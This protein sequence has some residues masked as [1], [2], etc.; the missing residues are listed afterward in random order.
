MTYLEQLALI[1][2]IPLKEGDRKVISCPICYGQKKLSI[3]KID[4]VIR[5]NCY[6]ASCEGKGI[7]AGKRSLAAAKVYMKSDAQVKI[8]FRRPPPSITTA[9]ENHPPALDYLE[10][11]N[12]LT[13]YERGLI[14]V[15]YAPAESR[16]LFYSPNGAV[17]RSLGRGPKWMTY[18]DTSNGIHIGEGDTAVL[19][20]DVASACSVSRVAGL[21][22]V[23]ILGTTITNA[24]K[25][26]LNVYVNC[27]LI[28][29]K[30]AARKAISTKRTMLPRCKVRFT[31]EDLK[32]LQ[33]TKILKLLR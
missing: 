15:R 31:S 28:L 2:D 8:P 3:S 25:I 12:S 19:V 10:S 24:I 4:G 20:E 13:A 16:V 17:G 5:W 21:V 18:G 30:D 6:R 7:H 11:V 26:A 32:Y 33:P 1:I 23:A 22:G 9:V 29:D 27:Y 14:R